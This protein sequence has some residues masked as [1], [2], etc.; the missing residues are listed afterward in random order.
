MF[1]RLIIFDADGTLRVTTVPGQPCPHGPGEWRL[2]DGV[3]DRLR[4]LPTHVFLGVASNQDHVGYGW[5]SLEEAHALLV[6]MIRDATG[7]TLPSFAVRCCPHRL[8]VNCDCRKPAP[9]MLRE[10]MGGYGVSPAETLFVGDAECDKQAALRAGT[11]FSFSDE[12]FRR[13]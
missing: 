5:L 7:R 9:G 6:L 11:H 8:E 13:G 4:E 3:Q 2:I 12:Y 1:P 10:I